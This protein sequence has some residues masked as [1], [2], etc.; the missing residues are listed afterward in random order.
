MMSKIFN[1]LPPNKRADKIVT[2]TYPPHMRVDK[3]INNDS[4]K[5]VLT[6]YDG[7]TYPYPQNI[8]SLV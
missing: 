1:Y 2:V 6:V 3:A 5:E 4:S 8:I 7:R